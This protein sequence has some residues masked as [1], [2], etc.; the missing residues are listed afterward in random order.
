MQR[1]VLDVLRH[2]DN[3]HRVSAIVRV[4]GVRF[5]ELGGHWFAYSPASGLTTRVNLES[6]VLVDLLETMPLDEAV[7]SISAEVGVP[8]E[9]VDELIRASLPTLEDAGLVRCCT[10]S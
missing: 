6:V 2:L 10:S 5:E 3:P 4:P 9:A 8:R 7:R 1:L